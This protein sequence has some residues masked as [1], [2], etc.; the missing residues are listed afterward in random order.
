M[1][2]QHGNADASRR[3]TSPSS[4]TN[5]DAFRHAQA[6]IASRLR[7]RGVR[8]TGSETGDDLADLLDAVERFEAAV[9]Q[10]GGDL[11]LDEPVGSAAPIQ[12]DNVEFVMPRRSNGESVAAYI[13]RLAAASQR[14][15]GK[16][17]D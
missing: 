9:E 16:R 14:V 6:E 3:G 11:M 7:D 15:R 4:D 17:A 12:P 8:L 1:T 2:E 13:D 5:E 10:A